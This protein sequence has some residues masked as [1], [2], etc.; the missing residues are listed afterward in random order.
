MLIKEK[1]KGWKCFKSDWTCNGFQFEIGKTY[2]IGESPIMCKLGFHFH[3]KLEHI[4]NYYSDKKNQRYAEILAEYHI[5]DND[6]SVCQKIT[7]LKELSLKEVNG[8]GSGYGDGYGS[9]YGNGNGDGSGNG[10]GS[11]YGDGY[12]SGDGYGY[13]SGDGYGYGYGSGYGNGNVEQVHND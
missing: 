4:F 9:G 2:D 5:S 12:G 11:G 13:G 1:I 3:H 7:I 10:Y 8:Y 6:K